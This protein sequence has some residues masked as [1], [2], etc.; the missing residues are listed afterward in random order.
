M[1]KRVSS[2]VVAELRDPVDREHRIWSIV[3][4]HSG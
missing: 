3:N 2:I 1:L 4:A